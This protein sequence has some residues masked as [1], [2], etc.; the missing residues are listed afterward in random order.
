LTS[1]Y[2]YYTH[3]ASGHTTWTKP[4]ARDVMRSARLRIGPLRAEDDSG[5]DAAAQQD[6]SSAGAD[7]GATAD[8]DV[9]EEVVDPQT[10]HVYNCNSS[11]WRTEQSGWT[12]P[13]ELG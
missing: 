8:A 6:A 7:T 5:Y 10:G 4:T 11:N 12:R 9:W 2:Y 3:Q 1:G 13:E